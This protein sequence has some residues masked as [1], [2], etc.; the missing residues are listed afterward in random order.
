VSIKPSEDGN[1]KKGDKGFL[2]VEFTS[3]TVGQ[4]AASPSPRKRVALY[5]RVST[6]EQARNGHSL[7][8][9]IGFLRDYCRSRGWRYVCVYQENGVSGRPWIDRSSTS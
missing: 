4:P 1:A 5:V 3:E 6:E 8:Q 9:Q 7:D 2:G